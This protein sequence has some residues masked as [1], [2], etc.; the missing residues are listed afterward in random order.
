MATLNRDASREMLKRGVHA[1]TDV[2]G[3]GL[4]GHA[5]EMAQASGVTLELEL[6]GLPI[7]EEALEYAAMGLIPAGAYDNQECYGGRVEYARDPGDLEM[8]LYDPQTSGGLLI[9]LPEKEAEGFP[10]PCIG[11][12]VEGE[13]RIR[14]V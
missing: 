2:T 9:A 7:L 14:V 8:F 10:W 1:C 12:V 4:V 6:E 13:G 11:R 3:F 5:L